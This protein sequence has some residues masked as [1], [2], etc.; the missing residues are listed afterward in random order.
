MIY[1]LS[2]FKIEYG[3][4]LR[5]HTLLKHCTNQIP[6]GFAFFAT[7]NWESNFKIALLEFE[8]TTPDEEL[9]HKP[10]VKLR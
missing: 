10:T 5:L 7:S 4:V 3:Q 6:L 1:H 9:S 8:I 2:F